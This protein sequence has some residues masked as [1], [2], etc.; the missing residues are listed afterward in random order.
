MLDKLLGAVTSTDVTS[1]TSQD[2]EQVKAS[3]A[4][5]IETLL[6]TRPGY[7][8]GQLANHPRTARSLLTFGLSDITSLSLASDRDRHRIV[9]AITRALQDHETR[10]S[11][12][13]VF[14][15][16]DLSANAALCFSIHANLQVTS[17][18]EPVA[19][20]AV[21]HPGSNRYAVSNGPRALA[22]S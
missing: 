8:P 11:D 10:L 20:D 3:V 4:R 21:L 2:I 6:N 19:F 12:V 15:R 14:V 13:H 22:R 7:G 16:E 5:D 1:A 18:S 9:C 17:D